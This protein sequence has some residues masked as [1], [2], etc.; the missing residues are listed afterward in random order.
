MSA[1][2]GAVRERAARIA[3]A[4]AVGA[5][6]ALTIVLIGGAQNNGGGSASAAATKGW[7]SLPSSPIARSEVGAAR[8]GGFIYVVGGFG[9]PLEPVVTTLDD[10]LR[11][12][13]ATGKWEPVAP[14]PTPLNHPAVTASD[15]LLYVHGGWTG[16]PGS[17]TDALHRF[18]PASGEW[19]TLAP[20]GVPRAAHTLAAF[21]GRIYSIGGARGVPEVPEDFEPLNLAQV[22]DPATDSWSA[23][24]PMR[25]PREHLAS[26]VV[27]DGIVVL[28]G[29]AR[30]VNVRAVE[31]FDLRERRWGMLP[32]LRVA[33]S[34]FGAARVKGAVIAVGGERIGDTAIRRV[35]MLVPG[36]RRWRRLEPMIVPRHGLGVVA[37]GRRV[38]ALDGGMRPGPYTNLLE[39][40]TV[41]KTALRGR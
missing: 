2:P 14:M 32:K 22:Y 37:A 7:A 41:P 26:V 5:L 17:E 24:P 10:V 15:G 40:L 27:G 9:P 11:Y 23:L 36:A 39:A 13:I 28:G 25:V 1:S 16:G 31:R 18:D 6:C 21:E 19:T 30:R 29:R 8:I 20:S 35:E 34:G 12:E 3:G 4:F 33:R 38:F